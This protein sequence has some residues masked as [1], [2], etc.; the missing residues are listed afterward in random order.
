MMESG[1]S[2]PCISKQEGEGENEDEEAAARRR[3][4]DM[5]DMAATCT[6]TFPSMDKQVLFPAPAAA[7]PPTEGLLRTKEGEPGPEGDAGTLFWADDAVAS[8]CSAEGEPEPV[9]ELEPA[10]VVTTGLVEEEEEE[11]E[12][13]QAGAQEEGKGGGEACRALGVCRCSWRTTGRMR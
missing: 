5:D 10:A 7:A 11:D 12:E 6:F 3:M 2:E 13:E 4:G 1:L 8:M 9:L